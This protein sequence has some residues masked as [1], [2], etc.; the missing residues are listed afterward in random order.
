MSLIF[1]FWSC[2]NF[3]PNHRQDPPAIYDLY[4]ART[5]IKLPGDVVI[6]VAD[7]E[8]VKQNQNQNKRKSKQTPPPQ[9][10]NLED[11]LLRKTCMP[12]LY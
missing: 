10:E 4:K 9:M 7:A 3:H 5:K 12:Q 11:T 6:S 8:I 1:S 2:I